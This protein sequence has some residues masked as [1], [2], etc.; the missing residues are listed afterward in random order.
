A[1]LPLDAGPYKIITNMAVMD[2]EPESKRMRV[3]S[4]NPGYSLK[5]IEENCGFELLKASNIVETPSPTEEA[6][7]L[8][9]EEVDPYKYII[10]R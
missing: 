5:D 2:F 7:R 10:G 3:I 9:R 8:L 1:G 6:L 4:V